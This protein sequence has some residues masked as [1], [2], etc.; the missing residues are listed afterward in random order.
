MPTNSYQAILDKA[1]DRRIPLNAQVELTYRCNQTCL[2]CYATTRNLTNELSTAEVEDVFRQ[3]ADLNCLFLS[4]TGGEIF[5]RSDALPLAW[6]AKGMNFALSIFTNGTL[7]NEDVA[8]ELA[9]IEPLSVEISLYAMNPSIHDG[10]TRV[11]GSHEKTL[12]AIRLCRRLGLNTAIKTPLLAVN[13]SEYSALASFALSIGSRFVFDFILDPT[14]DG[15][16]PMQLHGLTEDQIYKFI[17]TN[18]P[19]AP[20]QPVSGPVP[21]D[22][23]CGAGSSAV[24]ITPIGDILPCLAIRQ[25]AG[26]IRTRSLREI[27]TSPNLDRMRNLR[28]GM[29]KDCATCEYLPYCSRCSGIALAECGNIAGK[30]ECSCLVA[31]ATKRAVT[32]MEGLM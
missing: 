13:V 31:R 5:C 15:S 23:L 17:R 4:L 1:F 32:D 27:W 20:S 9:D 18:A 28:Y 22:T 24:C 14:D 3:L 21:T 30:C 26:N 19:P 11:P 29:L 16:R 8:A 12:K 10:I 25:P 2:H 7:L 6:S